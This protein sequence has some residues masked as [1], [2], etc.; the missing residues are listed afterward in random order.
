M[1]N[2]LHTIVKGS[3][4]ISAGRIMEFLTAFA[5]MIIVARFL[6]VEKYGLFCFIRSIG[7]ITIPLLAWG[8]VEVLIRDI[9]IRKDASHSLISNALV[10]HVG[11]MVLLLLTAV[12]VF[13]FHSDI[14]R[15]IQICIYLVLFWQC[16]MVIQQTFLS[17]FMASELF[18]HTAVINIFTKT[19]LLVMFGFVAM[20]DLRMIF[21]FQ[22]AVLTYGLGATG[23]YLL[24]RRKGFHC[25]GR[26]TMK[27][28]AYLLKECTVLCIS[29]IIITGYTQINVFILKAFKLT[30][31]IAFY[32]VP[33][34]IAEPL[35]ILPRSIMLAMMPTLSVS[36]Q[37]KDKA[38]L[39]NGF[40][41]LIKFNL[42]ATLP[43][44]IFVVYTA[45]WFIIL[46]L[47]HQFSGAT[48]PLQIF[49]WM[50]V[51]FSINAVQRAFLTTSRHQH[52]LFAGNTLCLMLNAGAGL[53]L[54]PRY[55]AVGASVSMVIGMTALMFVNAYYVQ[56][57]FGPLRINP[58]QAVSLS[59]SCLMMVWISQISTAWIPEI[60]GSFLAGIIYS[61]LLFVTKFFTLNEI[62]LLKAALH[63][64]ILKTRTVLP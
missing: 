56:K 28:I 41:K 60:V 63:R 34:R 55:G 14:S 51:P 44:C 62:T 18:F 23:A 50:I 12:V 9:S 11:L 2:K 61:I 4:I 16:F 7:L 39:L 25:L 54:I 48:L 57:F 27:Q 29:Q 53:L 37:S 58:K 38:L 15:E 20:T 35:Q 24:L 17:V 5:S 52:V 59:I 10:I 33:Q 64:F 43:I 26:P 36:W 45:K 1:K 32:Q 31:L 46:F 13:Q 19:G 22:G 21:L 8:S 47:G 30:D 49:I 42:A 40:H 3:A 6:G